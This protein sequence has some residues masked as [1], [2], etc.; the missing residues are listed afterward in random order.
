MYIKIICINTGYMYT[1]I[2]IYILTSRYSSKYKY[3]LL[4]VCLFIYVHNLNMCTDNC[5]HTHKHAHIHISAYAHTYANL[6]VHVP[7][8]AY[9]H[10]QY[11]SWSTPGPPSARTS[12]DVDTT[13]G[14]RLLLPNG[15]DFPMSK[16]FLSTGDFCLN[17][18][19]WH[20][21][22]ICLILIEDWVANHSPTLIHFQ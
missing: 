6:Y 5:L 9:L 18:K 22:Q 21:N 13:I 17:P 10:I 7:V 16:R 12:A 4:I 1:P 19:Q 15:F 3:E 8:Y 20:M 11:I 14:H 2:Y